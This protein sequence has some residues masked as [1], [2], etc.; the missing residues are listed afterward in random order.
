M[1]DLTSSWTRILSSAL[2]WSSGKPRQL[3]LAPPSQGAAGGQERH[4]GGKGT[5]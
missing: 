4:R 3:A 2:R 5:A 1:V